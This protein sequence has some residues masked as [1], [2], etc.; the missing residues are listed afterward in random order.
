VVKIECKSCSLVGDFSFSGGCSDDSGLDACVEQLTPGA[1][2][3]TLPFDYSMYWAGVVVDGFKI[4][5]E[6]DIDLTPS[7]PTN[8]VNIPLLGD[9]G[10]TIPLNVWIPFPYLALIVSN[11]SNS[12]AVR[13]PSHSTSTR[14]SMAGSTLRAL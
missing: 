11:N 7:G 10:I 1:K 8:E 13:F 3:A 6:L 2:F 4:H 5:V 9:G 12:A 14:A